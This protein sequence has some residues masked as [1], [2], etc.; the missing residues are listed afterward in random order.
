MSTF[1]GSSPLAVQS[2]QPD[3]I[4]A[5][6][7]HTKAA[8]PAAAEEQRDREAAV[9]LAIVQLPAAA[10]A[11][12]AVVEIHAASVAVTSLQR[13]A[14]QLVQSSA[15]VE[16]TDEATGLVMATARHSCIFD[17]K[18]LL[19]TQMPELSVVVWQRPWSAVAR[20]AD[21]GNQVDELAGPS[22]AGPDH[23]RVGQS[24]QEVAG[25]KDGCLQRT[26]QCNAGLWDKC[27]ATG[28]SGPDPALVLLPHL[29]HNG[30]WFLRDHLA[31]SRPALS[32]AVF[33]GCWRH[34]SQRPAP[35]ARRSPP[36]PLSHLRAEQQ[37]RAST[38]PVTRRNGHAP[39]PRRSHRHRASTTFP[40]AV[41]PPHR[42]TPPLLPSSSGRHPAQRP[43]TMPEKPLA[44][45]T[46]A[47]GASLAAITLIYVFG[48]TYLI[49]N[50][51]AAASASTRKKGVVGLVNPANDCFI[52][53]VLQALAGLTDLRVYLIR[54][55]HRRNI[56]E[57]WVYEQLVPDP[58]RKSAPDWKI[59]GLQAGLVTQGLKEII[60]ALN[61]RP[62]YKK[63]ISALGFVRVLE[64]AFRQRIS[65]QQQDA[66]EFLQVVAERLCDEY[67]AGQRARR[68]AKAK[69]GLP[70]SSNGASAPV[71]SAAVQQRLAGLGLQDPLT[72]NADSAAPTEVHTPRQLGQETGSSG[73]GDA[74]DEEGFPMEGKYESQIE[75][76]KCGFKP[77]PTQSTFCTLTLN[78]PQVNSATLNSCIDGFFKTEYVEDFKCEKC[79]LMHAKDML[80]AELARSKDDSFQET[81]RDS[82]AKL[83]Y[84]IDNDPEE[85]P[86]VPL[87]D[88]RYA[89][90]C[91]IARHMQLTRFPKVLAIHLS[92]SIYDA[93]HTSMKNSAK[94]VFPEQLPMGGLLS[95]KKYKLLGTVTHKGS[96][97]S[98]HYESFRRQNQVLP[99]ATANAFRPSGIFTKSAAPSPAAT[100]HIRAVQPSSHPSPTASTPDLS[101]SAMRNG[102]PA[103]AD[104][105]SG[106]REAADANIPRSSPASGAGLPNPSSTTKDRDPDSISLKS[107]AA[108]AKSTVSKLS[109]SVRHS[110][111]AS[112]AGM[113]RTKSPSLLN[114]TTATPTSNNVSEKTGAGSA[115][116]KTLGRKRKHGDRWW[117]ISDE[118]IKEAKTNDVLG[119]QRE[120][121][122]R[123]GVA[124]SEVV[125]DTAYNGATEKPSI[126][127]AIR[128]VM[129]CVHDRWTR[130]LRVVK[131]FLTSSWNQ[132]MGYYDA[133][134]RF[135]ASNAALIAAGHGDKLQ[136]QACDSGLFE[137][138]YFRCP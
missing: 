37:Q 64:T 112:P 115:M 46:Y 114:G 66:Q 105:Q 5:W 31:I 10:R 50:D 97:H 17:S 99:F 87:P 92:R 21:G 90:K 56:D 74:E 3:F 91:K 63:T 59:E 96:H 94:V 86:D 88:M 95:Q 106:I 58:N 43:E 111:S 25:G 83:Q 26:G 61:E 4:A 24:E 79:R 12:S 131:D 29:G 77:R 85:T 32:P 9:A 2:P 57:P 78:V 48:P 124:A 93:S 70:S 113:S 71:D 81:T 117:R 119:M 116:N 42:R 35:G 84:A 100:P 69:G 102:S 51:T 27:A 98:G 118:K 15:I 13:G 108:S 103:T 23:S 52:N 132:Y 127:R 89:P 11:T 67:H 134:G 110:R 125:G 133:D 55:T 20:F 1:V 44:V 82:I 39:P 54:E 76:Q 30:Q 130:G 8:A 123:L 38:A 68:A 126:T 137:P 65:R 73:D 75:C 7:P 128:R 14:V 28:W 49:D 41:L 107:V 109:N 47:A 60:D 16:S 53:S 80:E 121:H 18:P 22:F 120:D 136:R 72:D 122:S 33:Q 19:R 34:H 135:G 6:K 101:Y 36:L 129:E 45:A 62:I 104:T 138:G 40:P